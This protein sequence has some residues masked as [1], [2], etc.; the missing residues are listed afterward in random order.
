MQSGSPTVMRSFRDTPRFQRR[1]SGYN[2]DE[3][4]D[5]NALDMARFVVGSE[6]TLVT[7]T[8][9]TLKLVPRPRFK[10]LAVIHFNELI[11]SMEATVA[12]LQLGPTAVE[13]IG[14]MIVRQ[15]QANLEYSRM[16]GFIDGSPDS[17]LIVEFTGDSESEV[18]SKVDVCAAHMA[19]RGLGYSTK[20]LL[21]SS[22]QAMVWNVRKAGLG[23]MMNVPGDAKPLPF[24]EDTAVPPESLPQFVERFDAIVKEHETEAGYYGHASVGCLHIRPLIDLKRQDGVLKDGIHR[25]RRQ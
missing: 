1:V 5:S 18:E 12:A 21:T 8:E 3:L 23:L 11:E 24:V 17:L 7:I 4:L 22:E 14:G 19:K 6:G 20:K 10:S 25:Q 9:A 13:H 16:T 15:A 2:L